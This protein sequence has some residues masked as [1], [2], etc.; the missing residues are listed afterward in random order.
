MLLSALAHVLLAEGAGCDTGVGL[1][2][3]DADA[4]FCFTAGVEDGVGD[5]EC[6]FGEAEVSGEILSDFAAVEGTEVFEDAEAGAFLFAVEADPC[7]C[8]APPVGC[9]VFWV[10][11][12]EWLLDRSFLPGSEDIAAVETVPFGLM[13]SV[14]LVLAVFADVA[15]VEA[16]ASSEDD[17]E[18]SVAGCDAG[19]DLFWSVVVLLVND[20]EVDEEEDGVLFFT[21]FLPLSEFKPLAMLLDLPFSLDVVGGSTT[22][23]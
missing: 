20:E 2:S 11:G 6:N 1:V 17:E 10:D 5:A 7:L 21:I 16:E 13:V 3:W 23:C 14:G 15:T 4:A 12:F 19:D 9:G 8:S 18:E 22:S